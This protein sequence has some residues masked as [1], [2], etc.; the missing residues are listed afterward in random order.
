MV[1]ILC[2]NVWKWKKRPPETI[3]RIESEGTKENDCGG[4]FN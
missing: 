3:L 4:E 2:T 1:E